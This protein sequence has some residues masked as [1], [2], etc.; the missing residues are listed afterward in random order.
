MT[1][2]LWL[3][4]VQLLT[5]PGQPLHRADALIDASGALLSWGEPAG[6]QAEALGLSPTAAQGWLLAPMLVDPHSALEQPWDGRAENLTSLAA[7]AAAGGYGT[8]ALL[9]WSSPWRDRPERLNLSFNLNPPGLEPLAL[10]RW[11]SFSLEGADQELA[12]HADQITAGAIGLAC[13]DQLPPLA[14]LERGLLLGEM[15]PRPVL[16]APRDGSLTGGGFVREGVDALR[17]GWPPDPVLSE[18]LPLQSLLTLAASRSEAALRLMNLSTAAGVALLRAAQHRPLASVSWWH[19]LADS[20][21]LD[22]T[23]EGWRLHPSLGTADDRHAL[24][25]ALAD[26]VLTAVAVHHLPLD[27]EEQLLP[28]DQRRPGLAGHGAPRGLVLPLLWQE[29]VGRRSW[30]VEQ[31]WQALSWGGS[32]LLGLPPEQLRVGSRRWLLFDPQQQWAWEP[33]H[34]LSYAANQ[35]LGGRT[36]QGGVRATG[37]TPADHWSLSPPAPLSG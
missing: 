35:P 33:S 9:P 37:L 31:L 11:G 28:L 2:P 13:H 12:P 23:A 3:Q 34:S 29:L 16:V 20:S 19:L 25:T 26:G 10:E 7:A 4:Q 15:G 8:V 32:A 36:I 22:P 27:A 17:A 5:G 14:L 24:I 1:R 18:T 21:N 6:Q 30:P